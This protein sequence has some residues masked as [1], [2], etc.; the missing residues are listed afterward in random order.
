VPVFAHL[1][2]VR[3]HG[4]VPPFDAVPPGEM[5]QPSISPDG[6]VVVAAAE[7]IIASAQTQPNQREA[8]R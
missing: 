7:S 6:S 3:R 1:L 4:V 5:A 2:L 8:E